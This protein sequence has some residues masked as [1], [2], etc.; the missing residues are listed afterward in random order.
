M[1]F[2]GPTVCPFLGKQLSDL[3]AHRFLCVQQNED[4]LTAKLPTNKGALISKTG[5]TSSG[6]IFHWD[7]LV[8]L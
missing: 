5:A 6:Q 8:G 3:K 1:W 2:Y 4:V 7:T